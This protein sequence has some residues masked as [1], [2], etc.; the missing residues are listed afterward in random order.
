MNEFDAK[1]FRVANPEALGEKEKEL[2]V[3]L[4]P[5][6]K[7]ILDELKTAGKIESVFVRRE[8]DLLSLTLHKLDEFSMVHNILIHLFDS[9]S[10]SMEFLAVNKKFGLNE[11][12]TISAYVMAATTMAALST[13][14]FKLL[15]LFVTKDVD[16]SVANFGRTMEREAPTAWNSLQP[17]VDSPLRNALAHGTYAIVN[18]KI[19]LFK[20]AKLETL[21][22]EGVTEEMELYEFMMR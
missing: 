7:E 5:M 22:T 2:C 14:L 19:R 21:E 10:R 1:R 3:K 11:A 18:K 4:E 20:N 15:L 6:V 16:P 13:E 12:N 8:M 17:F 9:P